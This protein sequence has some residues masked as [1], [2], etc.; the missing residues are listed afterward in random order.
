MVSLLDCCLLIDWFSLRFR[1]PLLNHMVHRASLL[2][3]DSCI[4]FSLR[5]R[6]IIVKHS[7]S[8]RR[9]AWRH[10]RIAL[11]RLILTNHNSLSLLWWQRLLYLY[12][13]IILSDVE[14]FSRQGC[15]FNIILRCFFVLI[16]DY[17]CTLNILILLLNLLLLCSI[18]VYIQVKCWSRHLPS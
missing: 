2:L 10:L 1:S 16:K 17:F 9:F 6:Y 15:L 8:C 18:W 7:V 4:Y 13:T 3:V 11:R 12:L 14:D 5:L